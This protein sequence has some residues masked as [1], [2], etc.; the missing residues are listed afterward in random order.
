MVCRERLTLRSQN[1]AG[2]ELLPQI[3]AASRS[4]LGRPQAWSPA[5]SR[6]RGELLSPLQGR[7]SVRPGKGWPGLC[8]QA[9]GPCCSRS[10][11]RESP[12]FSSGCPPLKAAPA[13]P[14]R[15]A[16][17]R[18]GAPDTRPPWASQ[19]AAS[20]SCPQAVTATLRPS[21][22]QGALP[23]GHRD[24]SSHPRTAGGRGL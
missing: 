9:A 24:V 4:E 12:S 19:P 15:P 20:P 22:L 17:P 3:P 8:A 21:A 7:L 11:G 18:E 1:R 16:S 13:T 14:G 10:P 5:S 2:A 23:A 6:S